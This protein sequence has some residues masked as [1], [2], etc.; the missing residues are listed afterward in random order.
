MR[1]TGRLSD[2]LGGDST[3][4]LPGRPHT[5]RP[6]LSFLTVPKAFEGHA[7]VIQRNAL[8]S[9]RRS[10]PGCEI[11]LCGDDGGAREAAEAVGGRL[12]PD[13]ERNAFGTPLVGPVFQRVAR[14]ATHRL[15]AWST[16][17]SCSCRALPRRFSDWSCPRI[18]SSRDGGTWG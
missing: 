6:V 7:G 16:P 4:T 10:V 1:F 9:W 14:E 3:F 18:C 11:F 12:L 8:A 15:L 13:V 17:T 2:V 5:A